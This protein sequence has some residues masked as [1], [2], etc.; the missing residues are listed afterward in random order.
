MLE[1]SPVALGTFLGT[2]MF[3][4]IQSLLGLYSCISWLSLQPSFHFGTE[5]KWAEKSGP[6]GKAMLHA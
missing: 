1:A 4:K 3:F 6:R 5:I 2:D